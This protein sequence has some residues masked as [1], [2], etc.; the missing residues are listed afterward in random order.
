MDSTVG[1]Y[2]YNDKTFATDRKE[3]HLIDFPVGGDCHFIILSV[4]GRGGCANMFGH[5]SRIDLEAVAMQS[6]ALLIVCLLLQMEAF[7]ERSHWNGS[8]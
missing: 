1:G 2:G 4:G 3:A 7:N 6:C 8:F 5:I